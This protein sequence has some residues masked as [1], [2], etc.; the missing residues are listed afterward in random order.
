M[1]SCLCIQWI[2]H[3]LVMVKGDPW[4]VAS[5]PVLRFEWPRA[6]LKITV[7]L[8]NEIQLELHIPSIRFKKLD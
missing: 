8:S 7:C 5:G 1:R 6:I 3:I 2:Q 4:V